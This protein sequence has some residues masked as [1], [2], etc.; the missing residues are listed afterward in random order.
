MPWLQTNPMDE[1]MRFVVAHKSGLFSMAELCRQFGISRE[2]GY[3]W[4]RRYADEGVSGL[5]D[6]SHAP[7]HCPHKIGAEVARCLIAL[8]R[9]HPSWGPVTLLKQLSKLRP[10]L[11]LPAPSTAGD[12]LARE[13]LVQPRRRRAKSAPAQGGA[14]RTS[15]PN[16][17][18]TADYKGQFRTLDGKYCFPLTIQDSHTRFLLTCAALRSTCAEEARP[19]F[20]RSF[21]EYG[22]PQGI[23][24]D[25]GP[26]FA[27]PT[28]LRLTQLSAWWIKLG[29][30]PQR[31]RPRCPQDNGR[32]ERMHKDLNRARFPP[33]EHLEAQQ[34]K[35]DTL[36]EELDYVRPHHALELKTPAELYVASPRPMPDRIP[37]PEYAAHCEVRRV[38][39]VG[40]IRFRGR[41]IFISEVLA[42]E[43][44]ALEESA[45]GVWSVFFYHVLL[46]RF[47]E[48]DGKLY[49]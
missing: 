24:T 12:L 23:H 4:S 15:H 9:K 31:S 36:R 22:L 20:E 16:E 17:L 49:P 1:R 26:P 2:T 42:H 28:P 19:C 45:D 34:R 39:R 44:I 43:T 5:A 7:H 25:N 6:R 14:V 41:E 11:Q 18:W 29:I 30:T 27:A 37:E 8:R 38:R 48:R 33:G 40:T 13:G 32:H 35:F 46:A 10:D 47:D 3:T 21:R